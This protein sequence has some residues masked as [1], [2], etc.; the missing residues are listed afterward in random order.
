M[1][2][3]RECLMVVSQSLSQHGSLEVFAD[4]KN[5]NAGVAVITYIILEAPYF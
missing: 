3:R 4:H 2:T 5:P 1:D